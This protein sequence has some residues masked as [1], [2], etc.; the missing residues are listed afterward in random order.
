MAD[1]EK[2][3]YPLEIFDMPF[4]TQGQAVLPTDPSANSTVLSPQT[5]KDKSIPRKVIA[6]ET[7]GAA[8][9][10][11]S[12]KILAEF[13]FTKAGSLQIG[14]FVNGL[15]GDI[16]ISPNGIVARDLAG[17][18]T[19]ALNGEDG[20]AV[21]KGEIRAADFTVVD[22]RGIVSLS[23]FDSQ[24]VN[25]SLITITSGTYVDVGDVY[26]NVELA[27]EARALIFL[28]ADVIL[29]EMVASESAQGLIVVDIDGVKAGN[30]TLSF[31]DV[32]LH[33]ASYTANSSRTVSLSGHQIAILSPGSHRIKAMAKVL[34]TSGQNLDILGITLSYMLMGR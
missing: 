34:G 10:T 29:T 33:T 8:L 7:I 30:I 11:K 3:Y 20:S 26:L 31:V 24:S 32:L 22:E 1:E 27:R 6:H 4:P 2:V 14:E 28:N 18:T 15:S 9:N 19:F 25:D 23:A 13:E 21:F 12:R 16:R 17:E 5:T